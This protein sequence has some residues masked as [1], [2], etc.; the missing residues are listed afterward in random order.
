MEDSLNRQEVEKYL[1]ATTS[2]LTG[3][4]KEYTDNTLSQVGTKLVEVINSG[5]SAAC[6]STEGFKFVVHATVQEQWGQGSL[7][8][9]KC[10]WDTARDKVVSVT[11]NTDKIN[12]CL[13][14]FF[15]HIEEEEE[16]EESDSE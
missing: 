14:V 5:L 9:A 4:G 13:V 7:M 2:K 1:L 16:E 10:E 15:V 11:H 6:P 8:G 12:V 3:V